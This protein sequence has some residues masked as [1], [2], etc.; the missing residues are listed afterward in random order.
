MGVSNVNNLKNIDLSKLSLLQ[1]SKGAQ[2]SKPEYMKMT[3][4]IFNAPQVK[5]QQ[6]TTNLSTLNTNKS[7]NE[8]T[9]K[10][11]SSTGSSAKEGMNIDNAS[12]GKAAAADA[13]KQ[14]SNVK[15][16]TRD[17]ENSEKVVNKFSTNSKKLSKDIKKDDKQFQAQLKKQEADFKKENDKLQKLALETTE[18]QLEIENAQNELDKLLGSSSFTISNNDGTQGGQSTNPNQDKI[19]QLQKFIGSK[20]NLVQ[21]NGKQI[22]SLQRSS[23]RALAR[24]RKTNAN[25][26]KVQKRN[27]KSIQQNQNTTSK[28]VKTATKIEQISALVSTLGSTVQTAGVGLIALGQAMS[29]L[30][31]AGSALIT[32]GTM[33]KKVGYVTKMA[34]DYGQ[35]AANITKT[36]AFVAEGNLVGAMTSATSAIQTGAAAV[37]STTDLNK[38]F[39]QINDEA[40]EATNKLTANAAARQAVKNTEPKD[41][42]GMTKKEM[43]KSISEKLQAQM[44]DEKNPLDTKS[45]IQDIKDGK[46]NTNSTVTNAKNEAIKSFSD[47]VKAANGTISEGVVSGLDK[48]TR[49]KVG[50][51]TISSFANTATKAKKSTQKFDFQK[52]SQGVMSTAA[53]FN[54]QNTGNTQ[55]T[56]GYAPQWNL[57]ADPKMRRIRNS[58]IATMRHASYV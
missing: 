51:K 10:T 22:Y 11:S 35:T 49:N 28:V 2:S 47:N 37:K 39:A 30:F 16:L 36:A 52:F 46:I 38:S 55:G 5:Q 7:L 57:N 42:G 19:N 32:V 6:E 45:L 40:K 24:M 15:S 29:G 43:K 21:N 20:T 44:A 27:A 23:S 8:L 53:L 9:K 31:G 13:K 58:R 17:A 48:K 12:D 18:T 41:L 3:G 4:S 34:G 56:S 50:K 1:K 33:M 25:Y 26:V 54:A 14:T